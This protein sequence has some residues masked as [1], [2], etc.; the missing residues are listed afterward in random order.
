M[1]SIFIVNSQER[2]FSESDEISFYERSSQFVVYLY[3]W[4][5]YLTYA[6]GSP[7]SPEQIGHAR[8]RL[9]KK[10]IYKSIT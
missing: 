8:T 3:G 2:T 9:L 7:K 4:A 10:I 5:I 1:I 6:L